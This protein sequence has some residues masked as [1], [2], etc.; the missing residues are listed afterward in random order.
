MQDKLALDT[1]RILGVDVNKLSID[2]LLVYILGVIY[3]KQKAIIANV[4]SFALNLA[5][6]QPKFRKFL[7]QS[8]I[9]FCDGVGVQLGAKLLKKQI[10][11]RYTP[12]DWIPLL[13]QICVEHDFTMYFLGAKP[14]VV[15]V[16]ANRLHEQ[17]PALK[18]VG[19]HH[20]YFNKN[21]FSDENM[22]IIKQINQLKPNILV[23]GFG[24]PL[25]EYWLAENW[26]NLDVN[27]ALPV[28]AMFDYLAGNVYRA[29][30]WITDNGFEWLARLIIEPRRLW[31]RY[32]IGNPLFLY[33]V[34][35]QKFG[36]QKK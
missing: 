6:E 17:F 20:G 2:D 7:N 1:V 18:I 31:K 21:S 24:M 27:V 22:R 26:H 15:E 35:K 9:V 13:S 19:M 32:L 11:Y 3:E 36:K 34:F 30:R 5:Y 10:P 25:Q 14:G 12:P 16:A 28:G 4:N 8:D 29:P 23:I 33:R